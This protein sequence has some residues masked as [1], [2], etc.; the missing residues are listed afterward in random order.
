MPQ[1]PLV[2]HT[3]MVATPLLSPVNVSVLLV[4][5]VLTAAVLELEET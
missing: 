5:F 4:I 2:E 3:V 1:L